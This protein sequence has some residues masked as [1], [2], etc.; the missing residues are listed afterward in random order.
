MKVYVNEFFKHSV[1]FI[2]RNLNIE[3]S[4]HQ[5]LNYFNKFMPADKVFL[6]LYNKGFESMRTIAVAALDK[7]TKVDLLTPLSD[8]VK[9]SLFH[10]DNLDLPD[11]III[12]D[13]GKYPMSREMLKFH[14]F[15]SSSLLLLNLSSA[16]ESFGSLVIAADIGEKFTDEHRC[17]I[18]LLKDPFVSLNCGAIP[19]TLIDS[20]LFGHEKGAFT[21]VLMKKKGRFERANKGRKW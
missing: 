1:L 9:K 19:E 15:Q 16:G 2:C 18:S 5:C 12:N 8:Q 17:L 14:N 20:E 4:L 11:T 7:G 21:G 13:P 10:A 6:Q 3:I